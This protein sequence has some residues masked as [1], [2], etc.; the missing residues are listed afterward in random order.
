MLVTGGSAIASCHPGPVRGA[1]QNDEFAEAAGRLPTGVRL[2]P[3]GRRLELGSFPLTLVAAPEGGGD[4]V[5]VLLNGHREQGLQ[6][7]DVASG[8]VTQTVRQRAA[9]IGLAFDGTGRR[10]FASGG[11]QDLIYRYD[12]A[13]GRATLAD[14]L[15]LSVRPAKADG[16][17]YPAGLAVSSDNRFLYVAENLAD[18]LAVIDLTSGRVVQRLA[19]GRYPYAVVAGP[20]SA[21]YVSAWGGHEVRQFRR[22]GGR[23]ELGATVAVARHPAALL[24]SPDGSRLFVASPSTDRITVVDTRRAEVIAELSDTVP[25]GPGEGSTPNGLALSADGRRLFVAES[26][27]N[28]VAVFG[29]SAGSAGRSQAGEVEGDRL[30]GRIPVEWYPTAVLVRNDTLLV[31]NAKGRATGPNATDGPGPGGGERGPRGYTLD[32]LTGSLSVIPLG[33]LDSASLAGLAARVARANGWGASPR[34]T[35]LPPFE[36][37]IYVIKENRT[38]DQVLGDLAGADGDTSLVFFPRAVTPNHHALAE[39]FGVFDRFFTNAEVSADGHNWSMAA[40]VTDYTEKTLP[41]VYSGRGRSYDYEG[42]NR[43]QAMAPGEDVA[44][45]A[46]GY[47]WDLAQRRGISFRNFGE[48]VLEQGQRE[49]PVPAWY[50]GLKPFLEANTDSAFPGFDLQIPDQRRVDVWLQALAGWERTGQMPALQIVRLPNDHTMGARA[51]ALTPRAYVADNDLALGRLVE[52]LSRGRFWASTAVFVVEDDAQDGPDH[53][54]SHRAPFLLISAYSRP[55]TWH[56]FTNTTDVLATIEAILSL[57]HLSQFDTYAR[58]LRGVFADTRDLT[59]FAALQ[60][61]APMTE[62]NPANGPG[63]RESSRLDFRLEDLADDET[64]NRVLWTA[65][66]GPGRPYPGATRLSPAAFFTPF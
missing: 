18:S 50:R 42:T 13:N 43:D 66:K 16:A 54:D 52:A 61:Q 60:P 1:K 21:V 9:F 65:I 33:G 24:L 4:R 2:D 59:P 31:A 44:E 39:R 55:H 49:G 35:S 51:G 56:R 19:A 46:A 38:Y 11:N 58:P 15:V 5:V 47:L 64:F 57:N 29:L 32:Q 40:Y 17:R 53:V 26:D 30:L 6:V 36:H 45:P 12:W 41:Q 20:D 62:R 10:L 37:V 14:S 63:A 34:R 3:T 48:F 28:A 7:A 27:N 8:E 23:L 25:A 22:R